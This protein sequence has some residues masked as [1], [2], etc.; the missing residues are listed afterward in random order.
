MHFDPTAEE[1]LCAVIGAGV[2]GLNMAVE[3][4][5]R[6][7]KVT[8]YSAEIPD[9]ESREVNQVVSGEMPVVWMPKEYDWSEDMLKHEVVSKLAYDHLR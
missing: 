4:V 6:G 7:R 1:V 8:V 5:K 2:S 3:L 9:L